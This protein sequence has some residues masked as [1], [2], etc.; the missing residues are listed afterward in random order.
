MSHTFQ[1]FRSS[2]MAA[3]ATIA[4][5]NVSGNDSGP[6]SIVESQAIQ[7]PVKR[8]RQKWAA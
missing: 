2:G 4:I 6:N 3:Q 5:V 8:T 7:M 1:N